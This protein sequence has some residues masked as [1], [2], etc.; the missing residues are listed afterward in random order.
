[1]VGPW[2]FVFLFT[3]SYLGVIVISEYFYRKYLF[4]PEY[5]RKVA[6]SVASI[7]SLLFLVAFDSYWYVFWLTVIFFTIFYVGRQKRVIRSFDSVG[8]KTAGT[9]L[10]PV[11]IFILFVISEYTGTTLYFVLSVLIVGVSDP[12][13]GFFGTFYEK[14]SSK[15]VIL[16]YNFDK[17]PVGSLAFLLSSLVISYLVLQFFSY[18]GTELLLLTMLVSLVATITE[19]VSRNGTDNLTVP[20]M[21]SLLIYFF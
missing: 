18:T 2:F 5:S 4:N 11:A 19:L 8:R 16:G 14:S 15:L 9:Y 17:T 7:S 13:A 12:L 20:I 6:H 1:M 21:V 10:L 3:V